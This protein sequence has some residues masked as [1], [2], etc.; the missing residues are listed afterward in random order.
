MNVLIVEPD[1]LLGSVYKSAIQK[2]GYCAAL[3]K[4]AQQA[5]KLADKTAPDV[6]VLELQLPG[7]SGVEFLYEFRSYPEW[8]SIPVVLHSFVSEQEIT[9]L[10]HLNIA[11]HLYKPAANLRR[12][13]EA[14]EAAVSAKAV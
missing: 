8:Q 3:A 9:A 5:V 7:H 12:L 2:A 1:H 11:D 4:D 10:P 14:V 13:V 6:V